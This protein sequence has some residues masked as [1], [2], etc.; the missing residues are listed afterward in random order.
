MALQQQQEIQRQQQ[1]AMLQ[2]LL[3]QQTALTSIPGV[4]MAQAAAGAAGAAGGAVTGQPNP[5]TKKAREIYVGNLAV[6]GGGKA[7]VFIF[8]IYYISFHLPHIIVRRAL[9]VHPK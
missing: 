7:D 9:S 3:A 8:I 5:A 2:S 6:V 1:T 4:T